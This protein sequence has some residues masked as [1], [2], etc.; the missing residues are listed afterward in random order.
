MVERIDN[1]NIAG[2]QTG[3]LIDLGKGA[4]FMGSTLVLS[5]FYLC[6]FRLVLLRAR[7]YESTKVA[8]WQRTCEYSNMCLSSFVSM[9]WVGGGDKTR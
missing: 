3:E 1:V 2:K 8:L 4:L 5:V 9:M 6:I 7:Q